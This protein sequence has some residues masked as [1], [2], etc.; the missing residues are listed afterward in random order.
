MTAVLTPWYVTIIVSEVVLLIPSAARFTVALLGTR[1]LLL[2]LLTRTR[3]GTCAK[4][5][6]TIQDDSKNTVNLM[7]DC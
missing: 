3:K 2:P 4:A 6:G 5:A 1:E 7:D